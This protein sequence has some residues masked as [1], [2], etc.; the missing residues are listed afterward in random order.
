MVAFFP[1]WTQRAAAFII[2]L[3]G[4]CVLDDLIAFGAES[5][6]GKCVPVFTGAWDCSVEI[7]RDEVKKCAPSNALEERDPFWQA[8]TSRE[9]VYVFLRRKYDEF[10]SA[11]EFASWLNCQGF[12]VRSK[13]SNGTGVVDNLDINYLRKNIVP[14]YV[15]WYYPYLWM[16]YYDSEA[17][18]VDLSDSGKITNIETWF[19]N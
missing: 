5:A 4:I 1:R 18:V 2:L 8:S 14:Y 3:T 12:N 6:K 13:S 19:R 11:S 17:F 16:G 7:F 9:D 10:G 15:P